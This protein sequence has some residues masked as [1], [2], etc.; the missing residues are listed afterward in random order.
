MARILLAGY[1]DEES[2]ALIQE[3]QTRGFLEPEAENILA[4]LDLRAAAQDSGGVSECRAA[5][6]GDPDNLEMQLKLADALAVAHQFPE[7]FEICLQLI[8]KDKAKMGEPVRETMV[9]MFQILGNQSDLVQT[10]RRKLAV[11][12]Y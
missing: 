9:K 11:A 1:R 6:A 3:L 2:R 7:A 8:Q 4:E 12:L 5:V 10:Y